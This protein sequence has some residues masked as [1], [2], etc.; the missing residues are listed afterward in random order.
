MKNFRVF[1]TVLCLAFFNIISAQVW[2]KLGD[3]LERGNIPTINCLKTIDSV[4]FIGGAFNVWGELIDKGL[5]T[6]NGYNIDTIIT[7]KGTRWGFPNSIEKFGN[8]IIIG[9]DFLRIANTYSG[10]DTS[11]IPNTNAIAAWDGMEWSS[12]GGG[13]VSGKVYALEFK[14]SL[15]VGGGFGATQNLNNLNCMA[16]WDGNQW[17]N[18]GTGIY[19]DFKQVRAMAV[20]NEN[21][22]IAGCF[23]KAGGIPA[24][25]IAGWD[26]TQYFDLDTGV[27]GDV[28]AL[29]VDSINNLLYV[30]GSI[31]HVGGYNGFQAPD[32]VVKWDGF[33][34]DSVGINSPAMNKGATS[35][36]FYNNQLYSGNFSSTGNYVD[37]NLTRFDGLLWHRVEGPIATML[38]LEVYNGEL[39]AGGG[40]I[41]TTSGDTA[42]GA[43][44]YYAPP[45]TISCL[46]IQPL[47][48]AMPFGTK[49]AAD[50][51]YTTA[52]YHIQFYT[53]NKYASSWSWDF[54]DGGTA[55]TREPGHTYAA[56]GTYNVTLEVIHPHNLSSQ[57]CTISVSKTIT[58]ID[59]TAVEESGNDTIEYLGQN[60]PNP[61]SNSTSIPYYVPYGSIG[62]LQIH[63]TN[64]ELINEY[65]L[66]QGHNSLEISMASYKAGVYFYSIV[67][68]NER[69][70]TKRMLV[71]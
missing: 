50:T 55:N 3:G 31:S 27:L 23:I 25:N 9:G 63:N 10:N 13:L 71:E 47:I 49:E 12:V 40:Y 66:Q 61:F 56:P 36:I 1:I 11:I 57:V 52:P 7:S 24:Y 59:N 68:D 70:Q 32:G 14:N 15:Y 4:L 38:C 29:Q 22:Y 26:G 54:G 20:Y 30:G 33:K 6:W 69:K 43:A 28:Y 34:W 44:R 53:N 46:F 64:G 2:N 65:E 37:T 42:W 21:L 35:L 51:I 8:K 17:H 45:D 41:L 67:I 39:Y 16:R 19:G 18:V 58:I 62:L 60:I 5:A 48:H